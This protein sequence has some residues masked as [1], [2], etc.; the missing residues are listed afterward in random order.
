ME[1]NAKRSNLDDGVLVLDKLKGCIVLR[2]EGF[3]EWS[4]AM[5][6]GSSKR[7]RIRGFDWILFTMP[8]YDPHNKSFK[9]CV[10]CNGDS[11]GPGDWNCA[12]SV[13]L[14]CISGSKEVEI[15][16]RDD[17]KFDATSLSGVF[18]VSI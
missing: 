8:F 18:E 13:I 9:F 17:V 6:Y 3:A 5:R 12:A 4:E 14:R 10:Q 15:D 11:R 7:V 16:R 1:P 2:I